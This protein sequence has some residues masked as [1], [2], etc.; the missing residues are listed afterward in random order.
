VKFNEI[1][2]QGFSI[3][4]PPSVSGWQAYYQEPVYDLIWISSDSI[5]KRKV[6]AGTFARNGSPLR[7]N[8][9][10][11]FDLNLLLM[12]IKD[13]SNINSIIRELAKIITGTDISE[14]G[15]L[16]IKKSI[17]GDNFPDYYWSDAVNS[18]LNNPNKENY[19]TLYSRICRILDQIFDLNEIHVF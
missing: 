19:N 15:F 4:N 12:K 1:G 7:D 9:H 11:R 5:K 18:F 17:L 3:A 6:L 8:T 10:V 14:R 13:P 16:R 2:Q